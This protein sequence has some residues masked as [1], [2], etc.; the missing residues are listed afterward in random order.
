MKYLDQ[1]INSRKKSYKSRTI[2]PCLEKH[3]LANLPVKYLGL[4]DLTTKNISV[5]KEG[6]LI[7]I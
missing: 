5:K 6:V 4:K 7:P 3:P 1:K 2:K